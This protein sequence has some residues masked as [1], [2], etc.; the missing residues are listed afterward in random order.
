MDKQNII[1]SLSF[2]NQIL[3]ADI[4]P[5]LESADIVD[6]VLLDN[7]LLIKNEVNV[8]NDYMN[9]L[10][11]EVLKGDKGD[12][13]EQGIQ[14]IQG[15]NGLN[16]LRSPMFVR[17]NTV[18]SPALALGGASAFPVAKR[19][20][21][22]P[23]VFD[24]DLTIDRFYF[25]NSNAVAYSVTAICGVYDYDENFYPSVK[26]FES[27][28]LTFDG[29]VG[30]FTV[31]CSSDYTFEAGRLYYIAI[32]CSSGSVKLTATNTYNSSHSAL[33]LFGAPVNH[34]FSLVGYYEDL[35]SMGLSQ[36]AF[37]VTGGLNSLIIPHVITK[38]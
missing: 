33:A 3:S 16:Y 14:G 28:V 7:V 6:T 13:G 8:F 2:I 15:E 17:P 31:P 26:L 29:T 11:P 22:T 12:Q 38:A 19:V 20:Y 25:Y 34:H 24:H 36:N 32:Q 10:T 37:V 23:V 21:Y 18:Y 30:N 35:G 4:I 5:S 1:S 27:D 9:S